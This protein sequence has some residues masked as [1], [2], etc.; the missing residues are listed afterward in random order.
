LKIADAF[1]L[2]SFSEGFACAL[3]EAMSTGL[4]CVV[5]DIPANRQLIQDGEHG[6]LAP[7]G[8]S[9]AIAGAILRLLLDTNLRIRMGD[10]ARRSVLENYAT[11]RIA[12]RY[13]ALFRRMLGP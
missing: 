11:S 7:V 1:T 5:S 12:D 8:N 3:V 2:V 13:E 4:A 10:A 9:E 6:F